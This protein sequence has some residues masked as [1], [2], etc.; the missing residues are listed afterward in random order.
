MKDRLQFRVWN[1]NKRK[2]DCE[3]YKS[4][5]AIIALEPNGDLIFLWPQSCDKDK[6]DRCPA[7]STSREL[8]KNFIPFHRLEES[9]F[10]VC[11]STGRK[12]KNGK[13]IFEGYIIEFPQ[14]GSDNEI[15]KVF[16]SEEGKWLIKWFD[17][18]C[19]NLFCFDTA[20]EI[21]GNIYENPELLK[22]EDK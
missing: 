21:I 14:A 6:G 2:W 12:D 4:W 15:G 17:G 5:N 22:K 20:C 18:T 9:E 10:V 16:W 8:Y 7:F 1:I 3:E 11:Q 13:L 19:A